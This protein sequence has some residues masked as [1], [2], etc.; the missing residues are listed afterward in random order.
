M[1]YNPCILIFSCYTVRFGLV[2][3]QRYPLL[4][5]INEDILMIGATQIRIHITVTNQSKGGVMPYSTG[6]RT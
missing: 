3:L 4:K 6:F 2:M 1:K 5:A